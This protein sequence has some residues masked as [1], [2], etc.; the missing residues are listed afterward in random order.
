MTKEQ[1]NAEISI[2]D[3]KIKYLKTQQFE[4][5]NKYIEE[6]KVLKIGQK[7]KY[8]GQIGMVAQIGLTFNNN[9]GY[10]INKIKKDG[11]ISSISISLILIDFSR[12][13]PI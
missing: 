2:I 3:D 1:F 6:N 10:K 4:I 9:I 11:S 7:V 5:K 8:I 12:I 13:E